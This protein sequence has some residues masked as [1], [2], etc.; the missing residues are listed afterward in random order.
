MDVRRL[1]LSPPDDLALA[2]AASA[3]VVEAGSAAELEAMLRSRGWPI[4]VVEE[5]ERK[6]AGEPMLHVRRL[7]TQPAR[8]R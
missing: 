2:T 8:F 6:L 3:A 1:R 5:D 7:D 4:D